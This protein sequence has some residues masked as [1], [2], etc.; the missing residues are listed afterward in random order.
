MFFVISLFFS[1]FLKDI[2]RINVVVL[3]R[4]VDFVRKAN[5]NGFSEVNVDSFND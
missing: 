3:Y 1:S 2:G 4:R 5:M